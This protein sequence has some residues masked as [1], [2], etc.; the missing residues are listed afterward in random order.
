RDLS[1]APLPVSAISAALPLPSRRDEPPA[2]PSP[3]G[4]VGAPPPPPAP[5]PAPP[6]PPSAPARRRLLRRASRP[7]PP[8]PGA[9]SLVEQLNRRVL[10]CLRDGRLLLGTLAAYD[11]YAN[12]ALDA[13][14]ERVIVDSS[15][16]DVPAGSAVVVRGENVMLVGE[17]DAESDARSTAR[18][19]RV[20]AADIRRAR[21]ARQADDGAF[22]RRE[23]LEWPVPEDYV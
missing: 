7:R 20:S 12:V 8:P 21:S 23:R 9:A 22:R 16:A 1:P 15:Y 19:T 6:P 4:A 2:H 5:P 3:A 14:V 11:Q 10:V 18:F 13:P 17:L